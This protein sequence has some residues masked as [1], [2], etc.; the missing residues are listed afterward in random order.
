MA[1]RRTDM[2]SDAELGKR[3]VECDILA[4][5]LDAFSTV[6]GCNITD[7]WEGDAEQV[8]GSPDAIIGLNGKPFGVELTRNSGR[9]GRGWLC[10]RSVP[11][12]GEEK[13]ELFPAGALQIPNRLG[14]VLILPSTLRHQNE[15][16]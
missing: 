6:L 8:E 10:R 4:Q 5:V 13:R 16:C 3:E 2:K 15:A 7:D 12:R 9:R 1:H 14:D 11:D